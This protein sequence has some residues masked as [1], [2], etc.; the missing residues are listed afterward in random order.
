MA[1]R[2]ASRRALAY[3]GSARRGSSPF[4]NGRP[5]PR[6]LADLAGSLAGLLAV[7][8]DIG[9]ALTGAHL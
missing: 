6:L 9:R 3:V 7:S 4:W 1:R 2:S 5:G 8:A